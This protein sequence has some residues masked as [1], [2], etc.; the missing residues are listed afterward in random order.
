MVV[1]PYNQTDTQIHLNG[2]YYKPVS[3]IMMDDLTSEAQTSY[4]LLK[5]KVD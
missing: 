5:K 2:T 1:N 3:Q 4:I